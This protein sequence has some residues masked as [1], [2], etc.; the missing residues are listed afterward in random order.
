MRCR[1]A[2]VAWP[3]TGSGRCRA[4]LTRAGATHQASGF[5]W[6]ALAGSDRTAGETSSARQSWCPVLRGRVCMCTRGGRGGLRHRR[7]SHRPGR[8]EP[9]SRGRNAG[10]ASARL[11]STSAPLPDHQTRRRAY[12]CVSLASEA[13]RHAGQHSSQPSSR[14]YGALNGPGRLP[15]TQRPCGA[16][17]RRWPGTAPSSPASSAA[18]R[19]RDVPRR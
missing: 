10:L 3:C 12:Q 14:W 16:C 15:G 9:L 11:R 17:A 4:R 6:G 7:R 19:S 2:T 8:C 5:P 1:K 18:V 13:A